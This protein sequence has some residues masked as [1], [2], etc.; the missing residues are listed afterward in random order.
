[1][2][3]R[4]IKDSIWTSPTVNKMVK[5]LEHCLAFPWWILQ[6][7]DWGCFDADVEVVKGLV[8]P[9]RKDV[10]EEMVSE[11]RTAY[12]EAGLLFVWQESGGRE[13]GY[14]VTFDSHHNLCNKKS[15]GEDGKQTKHRR[16]TPEPPSDLL[17]DYIKRSNLT[18][19]TK[20]DK[21]RHLSTNSLIPIPNPI[22]NPK[23][24]CAKFCEFSTAW[25]Q[26]PNKLGKKTAER[27]YRATVLTQ[28]THDRLMKAM[29][30][31]VEHVDAE[32]AQ[33][34]GNPRPWQNG[35]TWFNNWQ[36]WEDFESPFNPKTEIAGEI[37]KVCQPTGVDPA[38]SE[39]W[40]KCM[41]NIEAQILPDNF[42][43]LFE[44]MAFGGVADGN[45]SLICEN[46]FHADSLSENYTDLIKVTM[47]SIFKDPVNPK[48]VIKRGKDHEK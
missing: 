31:Y 41:D 3:N 46:K 29:R 32:N 4:V 42:R 24:H 22:P 35:S 23:E 17:S 30:R 34:N 25:D 11:M 10:T 6:A 27:H 47:T 33:R 20:A 44:T 26:F 19:E 43:S 16:K 8:F 48:F 21:S 13:W 18:E 28:E 7:D 9:K 40:K 38:Q 36:E 37:K 5:K 12:Q 14:F 15:V 1:M 45:A 2:S 39:K